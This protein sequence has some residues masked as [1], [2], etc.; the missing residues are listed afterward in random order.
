MVR[1]TPSKEFDKAIRRLDRFEREKLEKQIRKILENPKVGKPLQRACT[2][3]LSSPEQSQESKLC[4]LPEPP[5]FSSVSLTCAFQ[6]EDFRSEFLSGYIAR[7]Q[8]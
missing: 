7:I 2:D 3:S 5:S 1:I 4:V 8:I 6:K